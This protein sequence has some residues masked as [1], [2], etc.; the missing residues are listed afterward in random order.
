[1]PVNAKSA[2]ITGAAG[3]IGIALA[4]RLVADGWSLHLCD[5]SKERLESMLADLPEDT[6]ISESLLDSPEAC[7]AALPDVT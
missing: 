2:V 7:A 4:Q 5:V 1:M 3:G 6:T